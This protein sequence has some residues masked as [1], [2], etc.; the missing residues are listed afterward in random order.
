MYKLYDPRTKSYIESNNP[1]LILLH[2]I[3]GKF[4]VK[5]LNADIIP[6]IIELAN[7]YDKSINEKE[8]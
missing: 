3:Q 4:R 6:R 2:L 8:K 7:Y 1:A 5:E